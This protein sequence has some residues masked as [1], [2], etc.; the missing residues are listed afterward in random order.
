[1][2]NFPSAIWRATHKFHIGQNV[3]LE[4]S[5]HLNMPGG[6]FVVTKRMPERDGEFEYRIKSATEPHERVVRESELSE[7]LSIR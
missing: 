6:V 5:P 2:V 3:L 7:V 1:M 4:A